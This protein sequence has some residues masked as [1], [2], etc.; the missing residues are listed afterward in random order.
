M[1]KTITH[2]YKRLFNVDLTVYGNGACDKTS[3]WEWWGRDVKNKIACYY[4]DSTNDFLSD[5]SYETK[6]ISVTPKSRLFVSSECKVSRDTYRNSGYSITRDKASANVVGVPDIV[7]RLYVWKGC[8]MV[9]VNEDE[10][11][12]YL[13][14]IEKY[15]YE[16][17]VDLGD[18]EFLAAKNFLE[19]SMKLT[20]DKTSVS[21]LRVWFL[22]KCET[23]VDLM[24]GNKLSVPYVQESKIPI[25][26]STKISPE[27]LVLWENIEDENLLV[28]TICTSDW[29]DY[30]ITI[31][32]LLSGFRKDT[33]W[34][35]PATGDFRRILHDIGYAYN[36]W[37]YSDDDRALG[38]FNGKRI[39]PKDYEM[40]QNYIYCRLGVDQ[41]G[42]F[43]SP[44][45]WGSL[46]I[47]VQRIM[48]RRI[49]VKPFN[50]P[51]EMNCVDL[52][53]VLRK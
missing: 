43:V 10:E 13:V 2:T 7:Q 47:C 20:V 23:L 21:N 28:R 45:Q 34:F 14:R 42:G 53:T 29:K 25:T 6:G 4:P 12:L 39:S 18:N 49:A 50:L 38:F 17:G 26:A 33:N 32:T 1:E 35:N 8:N 19:S 16:P 48:N 46:P 3:N 22:P 37:Y 30:P 52:V 11:I 31:L 40:L 41:N 36:T 51:E 44:A 27:T 24:T 9:A 15:G 5:L